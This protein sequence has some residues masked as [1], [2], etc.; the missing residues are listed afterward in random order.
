MSKA[1][2]VT[3][4]LSCIKEMEDNQIKLLDGY[5]KV[6]NSFFESWK[7][8][9]TD[10]KPKDPHDIYDIPMTVSYGDF[11]KLIFREYFIIFNQIFALGEAAKQITDVIGKCRYNAK[12]SYSWDMNNQDEEGN[13]RVIIMLSCLYQ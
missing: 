9:G 7:V 1:D 12:I 13:P 2:V 8:T 5:Y 6:N 4:V 11:G 10:I 3:E